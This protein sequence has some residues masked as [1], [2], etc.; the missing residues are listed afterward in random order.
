[1]RRAVSLIHSDAL[2]HAAEYAYAAAV[3]GDAQLIFLAGACPLNLDCSTAGVGDY[4][5]QAAKAV[6]N[7]RT[8]LE[9]SGADLEDVVQ[10]RVLVASSNRADLVTAWE[11]VRDAFGDH[12]VPSTLM[13]VT[14][15][16]YRDQLVEIEATA[17][18]LP[19]ND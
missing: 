7:M 8:A 19:G 3:P 5:V 4:A 18:I 14:V 15:L 11:V 10:T 6:E 2:S 16:G 12:D 1:M 9:V 17:A 13:G